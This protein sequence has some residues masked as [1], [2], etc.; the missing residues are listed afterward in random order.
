[1]EP[2]TGRARTLDAD[3][4]RARFLERFGADRQVQLRQ[5]ATHGVRAVEQVL[6]EPADAA[7]QRLFGA[8]GAPR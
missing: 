4:A 3:D 8:R 1:M 7:L 2:E 5:L 6:D